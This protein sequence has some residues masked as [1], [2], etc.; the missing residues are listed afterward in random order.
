MRHV[1]ELSL[2][3]LLCAAGTVAADSKPNVI[4]ILTDDQ[5]WGDLSIH[6]NTSIDTPN[7]DRLARE[8]S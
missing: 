1:F 8:V 3:G 4:V 6:G 2:F 7:L 5:G